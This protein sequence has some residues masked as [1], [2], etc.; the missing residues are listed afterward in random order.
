MS[1]YMGARKSVALFDRC[2]AVVAAGAATP[3][4]EHGEFAGIVELFDPGIDR[5]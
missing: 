3:L 4:L 5:D 1:R 2:A